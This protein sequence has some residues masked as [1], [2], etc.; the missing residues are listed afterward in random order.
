MSE[1]SRLVEMTMRTRGMWIARPLIRLSAL[2][3]SRRLAAFA[4]K[5]LRIECKSIIGRASFRFALNNDG[6]LAVRK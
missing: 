4:V 3:R 5:F 6:T 1:T 2:L